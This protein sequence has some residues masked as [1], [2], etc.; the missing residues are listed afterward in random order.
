[1]QRYGMTIPFGGVH[2]QEHRALVELLPELGYTDVWTSET[3]EYDA[4][5]PLALSACW[6]P[7][8]RLGTAIVSVFTR[9]PALLAMSAAALATSTS[10]GAALGIGTSTDVIVEGWNAVSFERPFG[11][12]RDTLRFLRSAFAG[13]KVD[14]ES[15]SFSVRGFRLARPPDQPPAILLAALRSGMLRLARQEADGAITNWLSA[16]DVLRVAEELG[17]EKELAARIFVCPTEDGEV[18]RRV[19]ARAISTYLNVPA[20]ASF[21]AWLGRGDD[22]RQMWSAWETGDR[23]GA[24]AAVTDE[25][26]DQLIVHGSEDACRKHIQRYI[27]NGVDTPILSILPFEGDIEPALRALAPR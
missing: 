18:V 20:Y 12:V 24:L 11:R 13:E 6:A 27:D 3:N 10:G 8:L 1:M 26:I 23:Q 22:L 21:H 15:D 7:K 5:T 4:F 9:G 16:D 14:I 19:A 2:L 17:A 25:L